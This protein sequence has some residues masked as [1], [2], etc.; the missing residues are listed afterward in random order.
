VHKGEIKLINE[1][2]L[3]TYCMHK[4]KSLKKLYHMFDKVEHVE[5]FKADIQGNIYAYTQTLRIIQEE[6]DKSY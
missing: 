4:I 1:Q 3:E 5:R 6:K 2:Y